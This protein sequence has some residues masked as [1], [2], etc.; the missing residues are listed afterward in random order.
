MSGERRFRINVA[1]ILLIA[2][3]LPLS[4]CGFCS[5][6]L[7][8]TGLA[9]WSEP[10]WGGFVKVLILLAAVIVL[11]WVCLKLLRRAMGM[12][13]GSRGIQ[14]TGGVSLGARRSIQFLRI[15]GSLYMIGVTDHH[16]SLLDTI[17]NPEQ[18]ERIT[19]GGA[20]QAGEPFA[21]LLKRITRK[22][23][24]RNGG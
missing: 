1:A 6:P 10:A 23:N 5:A 11:I 20:L 24:G 12:R 4:K 15:G 13:D 7:D 14:V 19:N 22:R 9:A 3:S 8:S 17:D 16:I 18:I 2:L 21:A